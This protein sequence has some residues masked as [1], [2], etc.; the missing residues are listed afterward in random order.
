MK[1]ILHSVSILGLF[2]SF[3]SFVSFLPGQ[4]SGQEQAIKLEW[5]P[6]KIAKSHFPRSIGM[7]DGE[8]EDYAD[9]LSGVAIKHLTTNKAD[10]ESCDL[11][12]RLIALALHLSPRNKQAVVLNFQLGK[13]EVP[14]PPE[15]DYQPKTLARLLMKRAQLLQKQ[16]GPG[17]ME[18]AGYLFNLAM[19]LDPKSED[20]IY[21]SELHR[22]N[23]GDVDVQREPVSV[24]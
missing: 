15:T 18:L 11:A 20:A 19:E 16:E 5:R 13:G 14:E 9:N 3:I 1:G 22:I 7:M 10:K 8:R 24:G 2:V 23:H 17:N 12:R 21:H 6:L 4:A